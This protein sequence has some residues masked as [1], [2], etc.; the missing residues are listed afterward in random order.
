MF[1]LKSDPYICNE[2]HI[3][4]YLNPIKHSPGLSIWHNL[5]L[6]CS[7]TIFTARCQ[8]TSYNQL[9]TI[10]IL[11]H[12][13]FNSLCKYYVTNPF[14]NCNRCSIYTYGIKSALDIWNQQSVVTSIE[15][16]N[17]RWRS[18]QIA[19]RSHFRR[20]SLTTNIYLVVYIAS[21]PYIYVFCW[22]L[23]RNV[24]CGIRDYCLNPYSMDISLDA[25]V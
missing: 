7:C 10:F 18:N 20:F 24:S 1:K 23:T 6:L 21:S 25:G 13:F 4:P 8:M 22:M 2:G 17:N 12:R 16:I 11:V 19:Y 15:N 9:T 14:H 5:I 3:S